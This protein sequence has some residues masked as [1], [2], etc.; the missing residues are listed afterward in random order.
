L[1]NE[2]EIER[3]DIR[4]G[5]TVVIQ[6]A[7][8]VIPQVV[9]VVKEL[10]P[11]NSVRFT[12]PTS[13]PECNS[14]LT[15]EADEA[16]T[17]CSGGLVCPA[18]VKERLRHF[19]SRNAFDIEGL[20]EENINLFYEKNRIRNPVDIF[21]LEEGNRRRESK[22]RIENWP[23]WK[24]KKGNHKR[25]HNLFHAIDRARTVSLDRF[26]LALGIRQVGE[27]T[28]RLLAR[29][30][31]SLQNWRTSMSRAIDP[32]SDARKELTSINGI[33]ANMAEDIMAFFCEPQMQDLLDQL[34][35]PIGNSEPLVKVTDF[36]LLSTESAIAG[37]T[38]VFTGKLER[39]TRSEAKSRA[40]S[41][42]SKKTDYVVAGPGAGS[43]AKAKDARE[44]G[45][46]TLTEE[47]WLALIA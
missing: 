22:D 25:A 5:D 35:K 2:D 27:A 45:I 16:D 3:K 33:G 23:G 28:A 31:G 36:E 32:E 13:C 10:R 46:K 21:K 26:I 18:Q 44:L 47:E 34:T 19:A 39:M 9:E 6:R 40:S 4:E 38:V 8:D 17:Y 20:G 24:D 37:K 1:H 11:D 7:G 42:V 43:K 29:H 12:F 30:Y 41:S 14:L 15:R